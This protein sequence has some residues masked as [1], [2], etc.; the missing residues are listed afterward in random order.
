MADDRKTYKACREP[1]RASLGYKCVPNKNKYIV[2]F[3]VTKNELAVC[4]F[5]PAKMIYW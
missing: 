5:V 1:V 2:V 3:I 4:E